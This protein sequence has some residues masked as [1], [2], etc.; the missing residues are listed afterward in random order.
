[1]ARKRNPNRDE[2]K[3]RFLESGGTISTKELAEKAGVPESRIRKWKSEDGWKEALEAQKPKRRRGA[4]PGN[5]N[6]QGHGAPLRNTNAETHGAYSTV[7]LDSLPPERKE[8]IASLGLDAMQN[9]AYQLQVLIAKEMDL[10]D[11]INELVA[12]EETDLY[13]DKVVHMLSRRT[14]QRDDN[15]NELPDYK[16]EAEFDGEN[17]GLKTAMKTIIKASPFDRRMKL[18]TEL[19]KVHGRIIKLLDSIRAY[20]LDSRRLTLEERKYRLMKQ[21]ITGEYDIDPETG[22]IDDET[23][24]EAEEDGETR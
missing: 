19:N 18:E 17:E 16:D 20:E 22:E 24:D 10:Q 4:Q 2:A 15:G 8:F 7:Y 1:M 21:K 13:V 14:H 23:E 12:A 5:R 3:A 9:M 6:A 11:R